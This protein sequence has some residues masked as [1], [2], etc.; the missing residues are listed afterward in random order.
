M[1]T[2]TS[3]AE[4]GQAPPIF[5]TTKQQ[6]VSI[7]QPRH[8]GI[9]DAVYRIRPIFSAKDRLWHDVGIERHPPTFAAPVVPWL[10]AR[11]MSREAPSGSNMD[12]HFLIQFFC[13]L[14]FHCLQF[15]QGH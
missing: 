15:E 12:T 8:T 11:V 4:V 2:D 10:C 13:A 5:H 3:S 14:H 9:E 6:G 1:S 7:G